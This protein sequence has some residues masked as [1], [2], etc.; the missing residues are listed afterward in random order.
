MA[1][2]LEVTDL[3]QYF[4]LNTDFLSKLAFEK[5]RLV[6]KERIVKAVNGVGFSVG[7]SEVFSIVGESGCGK[8]T[9]A[10]TVVRL[11]EPKGGRILYDGKDITSLSRT[12]MLPFRKKMQMIF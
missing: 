4:D 2:L 6:K 5:G 9:V 7:R 3:E 10:R 12:G 1:K 11:L 8:S